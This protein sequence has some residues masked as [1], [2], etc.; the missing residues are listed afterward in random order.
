MY[1]PSVSRSLDS[2]GGRANRKPYELREV[3]TGA[4][5]RC[6]L[7]AH[8]NGRAGGV[9]SRGQRRGALGD[10]DCCQELGFREGEGC[11]QEEV[12]EGRPR[13][14]VRMAS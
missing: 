5:W 14:R 2:R 9:E 11:G 7:E 1:T 4:D 6:F 10:P 12:R 13:S 3:L 8:G